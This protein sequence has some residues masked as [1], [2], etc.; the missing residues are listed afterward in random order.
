[1]WSHSLLIT[2]TAISVNGKVVLKFGGTKKSKSTSGK[3]V[4]SDA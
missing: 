2:A 3:A 4:A 1:V